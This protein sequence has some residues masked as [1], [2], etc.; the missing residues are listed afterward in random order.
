M[1]ESIDIRATPEW[2]AVRAAIPTGGHSKVTEM[3]YRWLDGVL[4]EQP[5]LVEPIRQAVSD[6]HKGMEPMV[7]AMAAA[8]PQY[9]P[10]NLVIAVIQRRVL[11]RVNDDIREIT[12]LLQEHM[13]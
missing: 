9:N 13:R 7:E 5:E 8:G 2:S 3:Q 12:A 1:P 4:T 6:F 10:V 11:D